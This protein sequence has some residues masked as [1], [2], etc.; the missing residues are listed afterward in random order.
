MKIR[1]LPHFVEFCSKFIDIQE[2]ERVLEIGG[3][4]LYLMK[5]WRE[6]NHGILLQK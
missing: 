1:S 2:T 4:D 5:L 6:L 3:N